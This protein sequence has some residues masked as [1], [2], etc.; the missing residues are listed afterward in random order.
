MLRRKINFYIG[1]LVIT[2]CGAFATL[3]ITKTAGE[4]G[5]YDYTSLSEEVR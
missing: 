5:S 3:L 1:A 2:V 4:A